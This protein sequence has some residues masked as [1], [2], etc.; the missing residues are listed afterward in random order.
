MHGAK[1]LE[2]RA[3]FVVDADPEPRNADSATLLV[4]WPVDAP[5]PLVCAFVYSET[6]CAPSL[7]GLRERE[8][9]ARRREELN[10]LYV[11]MTRAEER[12][13]F[14]ATEPSRRV[15]PTWWE[16]VAPHAAESTTGATHVPSEALAGA[17]A[18]ALRVLPA[19]VAPL[20]PSIGSEPGPRIAAATAAPDD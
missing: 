4:D 18:A 5:H 12:L 1:G 11:A 9:A 20:R 10:G 15:E 13:C 8:F 7:E 16:R 14:S 3:V 17:Q 6:F 2:A 19:W